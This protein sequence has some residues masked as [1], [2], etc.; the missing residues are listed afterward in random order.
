MVAPDVVAS[1]YY[2]LR[3]AT[4]DGLR[5]EYLRQFIFV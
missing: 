5:R 2:S 4:R 1:W 3:E